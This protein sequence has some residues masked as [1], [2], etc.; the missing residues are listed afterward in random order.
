MKILNSFA[1]NNSNNQCQGNDLYLLIIIDNIYTCN[2]Q[3]NNNL[4]NLKIANQFYIPQINNFNNLN[5]LNNF[6]N[7]NF[8]MTNLQS[9]SVSQNN[10]YSNNHINL[11]NN[12]FDVSNSTYLG[13]L[14]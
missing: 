9:S 12:S 13:I 1:F 5:N 6:H 4:Q 8:Q 11:N 7:Y 2:I 3:T 10:D 14:Q